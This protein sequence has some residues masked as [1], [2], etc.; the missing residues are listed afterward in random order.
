MADKGLES[1][2]GGG[3]S[4]ATADALKAEIGQYSGLQKDPNTGEYSNYYSGHA[5]APDVDV[6]KHVDQYLH[7]AAV[8]KWGSDVKEQEDVN[9]VMHYITRAGT[10]ETLSPEQVKQI[11]NSASN[12]DTPFVQSLTQQKRLGTLGA[13]KVT[14]DQVANQSPEAKNT[15]DQIQAEADRQGT[16]FGDVYR[17]MRMQHVQNDVASKMWEY[18]ISKYAVNNRTSKLEDDGMTEEAKKAL[19]TKDTTNFG[20]PITLSGYGSDI[21]TPEAV[22]SELAGSAQKQQAAQAGLADWKQ[23]NG[24]QQQGTGDATKFIDKNGTDVTAQTLRQQAIITQEQK[25][26]SIIK[27]MDADAKKESGFNPTPKQLADAED[28]R[29]KAMTV[30][31]SPVSVGAY[32]PT[33]YTAAQKAQMGQS[34][35]DASLRTV[36]NYSK[37]EQALKDKSQKLNITTL[38]SRFTKPEDNKKLE[39]LVNNLNV[40]GD[41][42]NNLLGMQ[43]IGTSKDGQQLSADEYN[44]LKGKIGFAG[45]VV[46]ADGTMRSIFKATDPKTKKDVQFSMDNIASNQSIPKLLGVDANQMITQQMIRQATSSPDNTA[47]FPIGTAGHKLSIKVLHPDQANQNAAGNYTLSILDKDGHS[48]KDVPVDNE[49]EVL[50]RVMAIQKLEA[51]HGN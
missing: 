23:Q 20:V 17:Q 12:V 19:D 11:I 2:S 25:H 30:N 29:Q 6:A 48:I 42:D 39:E 33:T 5:I 43:H 16:T 1:R 50:S 35:Y 3:I 14:Y 37:Y 49:S 22:T 38:A 7:D 32:L 15:A 10:S 9:G 8:H 21:N 28:A 47:T 27:Q 40:S 41:A 24:V 36:Q 26:Q 44:G 46:G 31:E 4:A 13:D 51:Q 34:A 18:G 45:M